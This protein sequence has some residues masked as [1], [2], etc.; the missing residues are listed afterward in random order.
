MKTRNLISMDDLTKEDLANLLKMADNLKGKTM[1]K[2]GKTAALLFNRP[3]TRTHVS[4][5]V[6]LHQMGYSS[7][8]LDYVF[9]QLVRG[10]KPADSAKTL[11][12]YV[13]L[14]IARLVPHS[15][16][17]EVMEYSDVPVVNAGSDVEHPCQA[18]SDIYTVYQAG[19]LKPGSKIVFVGDPNDAVANSLAIAAV[20]L[21]LKFIYLCPKGYYPSY[22]PNKKLE[23]SNDLRVVKDATAIYTNAWVQ[24]LGEESPERTR[25]FLPYQVNEQMLANAPKEVIVM[26]PLPAFRGVEISDGVLDGKNSIVWQ[27]VKN[28]VYVQKAIISMLEK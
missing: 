10:E 17:E 15:M 28:R 16:L 12:Q 24:E 9:T 23:V 22:A 25:D 18:L 1:Q 6:A 7:T 3:S 20:K 11:S 4:F 19:K 21:G 27:Q 2:N 8:Y 5:D 26:H 14:I 13:S